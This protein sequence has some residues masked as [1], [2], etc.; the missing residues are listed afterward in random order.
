MTTLADQLNEFTA[1]IPAEIGGRIKTGVDEVATSGAAPGL[2]VGDTAPSFTLNDA[3][4]N[5]IVLADLL[6]TGRGDLL[7]GGV[8]PL[9]QSA[10]GGI[11][12][13]IA[14]D[15]RSGGDPRCH[16]PAGAGP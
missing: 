11:A 2:A 5:Q 9:L 4:G 8:V 16:Q 7:S 14:E 10:A 1:Q 13:G 12:E 6:A 15:R 3:I